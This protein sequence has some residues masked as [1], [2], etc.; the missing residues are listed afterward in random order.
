M[1]HMNKWEWFKF[2]LKQLAIVTGKRISQLR[3]LNKKN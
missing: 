3:K 1:L 2:E